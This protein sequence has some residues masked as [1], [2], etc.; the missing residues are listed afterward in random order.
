VDEFYAWVENGYNPA[1]MKACFL[2]RRWANVVTD[3][4]LRRE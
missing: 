3:R 1:G 2:S 4:L